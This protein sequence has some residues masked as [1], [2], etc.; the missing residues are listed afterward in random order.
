MLYTAL[1][2]KNVRWNTDIGGIEL[3]I[4][5]I[6]NFGKSN[7]ERQRLSGQVFR[8]EKK[9]NDS[10]NYIA[11]SVNNTHTSDHSLKAGRSQLSNAICRISLWFF[12]A[13]KSTSGGIVW[14]GLNDVTRRSFV[15]YAP[16][17]G[18]K[19]AALTHTTMR[20]TRVDRRQRTSRRFSLRLPTAL[21]RRKID[22]RRW[23]KRRSPRR[24][25]LHAI[26][27]VARA[28]V[29]TRVHLRDHGMS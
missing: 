2:V 4:R 8:F 1:Q 10:F 12:H 6:E 11:K 22:V 26:V 18:V 19:S 3:N 27:F 7:V 16:P 14:W 21:P 17:R 24:L 9:L 5:V 28:L 20:R 23:N 29:M 13:E 15:R 25:A